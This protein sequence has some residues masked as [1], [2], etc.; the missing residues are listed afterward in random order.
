M[1]IGY[2]AVLHR[3]LPRELGALAFSRVR[4]MRT[5]CHVNALCRRHVAVRL[6]QGVK[7]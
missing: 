3:M 2:L 4:I 1:P 7:H 6:P 5:A